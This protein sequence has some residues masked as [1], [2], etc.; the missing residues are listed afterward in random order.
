MHG[1][2][3]EPGTE[4]ASLSPERAWVPVHRIDVPGWADQLGEGQ[5]KGARSRAQISPDTPRAGHTVPQQRD[6]IRMI[7]F[8]PCDKLL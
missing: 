8:N 2:F 6:V 5:R 4:G 7:H 1:E 3:G